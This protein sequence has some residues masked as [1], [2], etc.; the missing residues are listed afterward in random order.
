MAIS[1]SRGID[2][3]DARTEVF[4]L[5]CWEWR[6]SIKRTPQVVAKRRTICSDV[7]RCLHWR[8]FNGLMCA[9]WKKDGLQIGSGK[10][11]ERFPITLSCHGRASNRHSDCE[12]CPGHPA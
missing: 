8:N 6:R 10:S 9:S 1:H 4:E 2:R 11:L 3:G 5:R 12:G 7:W